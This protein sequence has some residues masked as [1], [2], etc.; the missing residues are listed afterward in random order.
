MSRTTN[1]MSAAA[2]LTAAGI[3][4]VMYNNAYNKQS[5]N[6]GDESCSLETLSTTVSNAASTVFANLPIPSPSAIFSSALEMASSLFSNSTNLSTPTPAPESNFLTPENS[7]VRTSLD[8][9]IVQSLINP[10]LAKLGNASNVISDFVGRCI[11][12]K[13]THNA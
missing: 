4:Y 2:A 3:A 5:L 9:S 13:L 8:L 10:C 11:V 6:N 12:S 1:I 7:Q